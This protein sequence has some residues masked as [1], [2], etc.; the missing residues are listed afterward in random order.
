MWHSAA[1]PKHWAETVWRCRAGLPQ[2]FLSCIGNTSNHLSSAIW[3]IVDKKQTNNWNNINCSDKRRCK[4][5]CIS[6]FSAELSS[7]N[8]TTVQPKMKPKG[9]EWETFFCQTV[10]PWTLIFTAI[11]H[12]IK[13]IL[14]FKETQTTLLFPQIPLNAHVVS[15]IYGIELWRRLCY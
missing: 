2:L 4:K 13:N 10:T 15:L 9:W 3:F 12:S 5:L 1:Q 11:D 14:T 8:V 6:S 7:K